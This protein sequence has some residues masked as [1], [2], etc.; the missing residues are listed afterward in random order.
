[1]FKHY[2]LLIYRNILRARNYFV[3]NLVG[4]ATGLACTL[5]I[6]LW[7]RDEYRINKFH[8]NDPVLYQVMEH[9]QYSDEI[10]TTNSTPGLLAETLKEEFPEVQYAATTTWINPFTLSVD[11]VNI[12][13]N[14]FYV[15]TDFFL[16]FSFP[17]IHG[18][19]A[20]VLQDKSGIVISRD[21]AKRLFVTEDA[22]LGKTIE[23][24]HDKSYKV[25]GV[26][27]DTPPTSSMKFDFVLSFEEFKADNQWVLPWGNNGP[28]TYIV[29]HRGTDARAFEE[30]IQ[31]F[32]KTKHEGSHV[33]L[34]LQKYSERYLH[35]NFTNGK[36]SGGRIEYV[37]LFSI[38]AAFI[39]IIACINFMNLST[40]RASRKAREVGIK[41]SIGAQRR[42]LIGQY[43]SE[44]ILI[45]LLALFVA[46]G[47]V[48]LFLPQ[49]NVITGKQIQFSLTDGE[50]MLSLITITI[51]TGVISG[52]YPALYLSGF[53]PAQV[54]KG[55]VRG[56]LGELWA[57]KGLVVFQFFLSVI[58][59]VSVLVLYQQ[60]Q[61]VQNKNLGY[62]RHNLI[63]V[64]IEGKIRGSLET[65]VNE[66]KRVP[67]VANASA[68]G[69]R[70]L[71][72][73]NNTLSVEWP[74]KHPGDNILFENVG[75]MAGLP[76]TLGVELVE[77]RFFT[78]D[79]EADTNKIIFNEAAIR[80]M[81]L[82]DPI[83][84]KVKLWEQNE[85]E[86]IGV[87][88]NFHFQSLH[89]AVQPLF[90]RFAPKNTWNVVV[91]LEGGKEKETLEH[92]EKL[93]KDFNPG[94]TFAYQF[95]DQQ[96]AR[97]YEAEQRVATLSAYFAGMAVV[98]SC[99]GL[100]G[101]ANFTA[102]RRLKEIGIRKA[103]GSSSS[104]IVFLLSGDF[105][106]MVLISIG[107]GIP[108][109]WYL[110][111][112]WLERFAFHIELEAW[113]F[114]LAGVLA[115][116]IAWLTVASQAIRAASVNP[117]NCL[118]SGQ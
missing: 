102:E 41:K 93:Y 48:W 7:V 34:F 27:A 88:K 9:Q 12:K 24:Q 113:Y 17:L 96:Y 56:S 54:L 25:T 22:A 16:I 37:K 80:V 67:G 73:A 15:G 29:L 50:L 57:R 83:G 111:T 18:D 14:G 110:L 19:A 8:E 91:R 87:V 81:N 26:F 76:E 66:V 23:L 6:F 62:K 60:I 104:N 64:P 75:A 40:A 4:L 92:L 105:T 21:L 69:H 49:F 101:L 90:F 33:T 39:L 10:M 55:E 99:L 20:Q 107:L 5:L 31:G 114:I 11:E 58:L 35:G 28:S 1:M 94:F 43:L 70:F 68:S 82:K 100:F 95:Q 52:S 3:I 77:G 116:V 47:V 59:I 89:D 53:R 36:P 71:G 46:V 106:K 45:S 78:H 74:G 79:S 85:R 118:R 51:I 108:A 109:S 38:I 32:I 30:K 2:L 98:I 44:S 63:L 84:Q 13:S 115:L 117:V 72:R 42:A 112:S 103:L 97:L 61:F 65:F 86:I